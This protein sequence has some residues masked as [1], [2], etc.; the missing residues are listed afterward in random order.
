MQKK[1]IKARDVM[2]AKHL[3]LDGMATVAQALQAMRAEKASVVIVKKRN[4]HDAFGILLLSDIAKKVLAKDRAAERV[5]VYEIMSKPVIPVDP[6]MD[7][8][9]CARLFDRFGLSNAPVIE[10]GEVIGIVSYDELVFD[11]LCELM[12]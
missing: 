1:V 3:E 9:Y 6:E 11:G 5:N 2:V 7:V 4:E 8:R 12:D 10:N